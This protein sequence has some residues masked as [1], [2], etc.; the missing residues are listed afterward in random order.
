MSSSGNKL[1]DLLNTDVSKLL[2]PKE[3][4]EAQDT[5]K[6]S[7]Q[8]VQ[9][10]SERIHPP[11]GSS[12]I[13]GHLIADQGKDVSVVLWDVSE[14]GAC[15][16]GTMNMGGF[17]NER[18]TL[19]M[20]NEGRTKTFEVDVILRWVDRISPNLFF[21]GISFDTDPAVIRGSFLSTYLA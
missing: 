13:D 20:H 5:A 2:S 17:V 8:W 12:K 14:T 6:A 15:L 4:L 10:Q 3:N 19:L 16:R 21:T 1:I 7:K 11:C 9:R 18:K